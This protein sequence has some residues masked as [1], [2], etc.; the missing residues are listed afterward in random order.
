MLGFSLG[1]TALVFAAGVLG[2]SLISRLRSFSFA[3]PRAAS[4]AILLATGGA[5]IWSGIRWL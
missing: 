2:G 3:G 1:D 4:A 5:L